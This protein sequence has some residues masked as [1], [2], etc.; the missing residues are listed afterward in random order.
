LKQQRSV[1]VRDGMVFM[2]KLWIDG[3]KDIVLTFAAAGA[4]IH[5][6]AT[7]DSHRP[8]LFYRVVGAGKKFDEQLDLFEN[9]GKLGP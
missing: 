9:A 1:L 7:H 6:F 5:D 2:F 4:L 3:L 8:Q